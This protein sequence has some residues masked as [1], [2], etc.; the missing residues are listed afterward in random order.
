MV[1]VDCNDFMVDISCDSLE[2]FETLETWFCEHFCQNVFSE[3]AH[4]VRNAKTRVW[5]PREST[6]KG[7]QTCE[8]RYLPKEHLG[9]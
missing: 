5:L 9:V 1:Q 2:T 6:L 3:H 8:G 4:F 7:R